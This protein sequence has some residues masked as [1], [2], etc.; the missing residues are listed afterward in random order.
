VSGMRWRREARI[1]TCAGL[2]ARARG[3][4]EQTHPVLG[5][6]WVDPCRERVRG[7][8]QEEVTVCIP[9]TIDA[10]DLTVTFVMN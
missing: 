6:A 5:V 2:S 1:Q 4:G 9:H 8:D 10:S 7:F 3:R